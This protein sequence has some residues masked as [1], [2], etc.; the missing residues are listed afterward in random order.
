MDLASLIGLLAAM[1]MVVW[2]L[3]VGTGGQL[4][5][6]WDTPS[7]IL[8]FGGTLFTVLNTQA[9]DKF[10]A[11]WKIV[12]RS[13][14]HGRCSV[15]KTIEQIV[16]LGEMA[17]REGVLSLENAM[18]EIDDQ[19]LK[20][21]VQLV[22]DGTAAPEIEQI[23]SAELEALDQRHSQGKNFLDLTA[24]YA[25]AY[26][27]IGTLM[28]L[29]AMLKNMDDPKKIGPGMAVAILTTFYGAM[30]ANVFC[31]PMAD[32]LNY[33]H[34]EEMLARTVMLKGILALQAGDNPR[35]IQAKLA[36][37]LATD[38]RQKIEGGGGGG[39]GGGRGK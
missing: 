31:L 33:R 2:S 15:A 8:V 12:R 4:S 22:V 3:W 32:K 19:F 25:P 35:V 13:F 5:V 14:F 16:R 10:L 23:M 29:V 30:I 36:V 28:G 37:Y 39:G 1:G 21:G 26:G 9:L 7:V 20:N 38:V 6:Y 18:G 34:E 27:M 17:R 11:F 24:K